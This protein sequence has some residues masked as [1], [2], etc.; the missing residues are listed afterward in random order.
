[1]RYLFIFS[2]IVC[3]LYTMGQTKT[4]E[5]LHKNNQEAFTLFFYQNTL[6][7]F[8]QS[9]DKAF[10]ELIKDIEKMKFIM[11]DKKTFGQAEYKKLIN[12]YKSESFEEIMSSRVEGKNFDV[13]LKESNGKTKGMIVTVN[14]TDKLFVLDIVG[15]I[16]LNKVATFVSTLDKNTEITNKIKEFTSKE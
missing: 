8:N 14:D 4:T 6:R 7:M 10:D 5:E 1:M 12:G 9:D 13:F 3:S 16:A 2:L 15:S 11:V